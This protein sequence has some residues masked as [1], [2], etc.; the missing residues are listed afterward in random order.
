MNNIRL[1]TWIELKKNTVANKKSSLKTYIR[2][3]SMI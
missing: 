1:L 2:Q 3:V